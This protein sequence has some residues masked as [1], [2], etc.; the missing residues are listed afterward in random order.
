MTEERSTLVPRDSPG[1]NYMTK[2]HLVIPERFTLTRHP[3]QSPKEWLTEGDGWEGRSSVVP[4]AACRANERRV[5]V[6][7]IA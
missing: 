7:V 3:N 2:I 6:G 5:R 4:L 1:G